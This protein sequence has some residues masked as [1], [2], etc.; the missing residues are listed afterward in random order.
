MSTLDKT[1]VHLLILGILMPRLPVFSLGL[2]GVLRLDHLVI[3]AAAP[4]VFVKI[5]SSLKYSGV[6][7]LLLLLFMVGSSTFQSPAFIIG[8][9]YSVIF[10]VQCVI[11]FEIA[12]KIIRFNELTILRNV[13][14]ALGF[15]LLIG[16]LSRIS[17][18]R[19]CSEYLNG[20]VSTTPCYVDQ[21]GLSGAPYV[22]GAHAVAFMFICLLLRHGS[23]YILGL[24]SLV[25]G[26]SRAFFGAF[27]PA[28][29]LQY[30]KTRLG[31]V[32][33]IVLM[34]TPVIFVYHSSVKVI[35]GFAPKALLDRSLGMRLENFENFIDWLTL[36]RVMLGNGYA[37]YLDFAVQYG[38][39]G[40]PDN[41]FIRAI[42]EF[43]LIGCLVVVLTLLRIYLN[44]GLRVGI[45][46]LT[47]VLGI[48]ALGFVQESHLANKS[49][50]ILA[51]VAGL[52]L[53]RARRNRSF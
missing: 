48:L 46:G 38:Q 19:L 35:Q 9:V 37:S 43:G 17:N 51:F 15:N 6:F 42:S 50:Q 28:S 53:I 18:F 1:F 27:M 25:L 22:F 2:L 11:Y 21:Y 8:A 23:A 13:F 44:S 24:L 49:G 16:F 41:L 30:L 34:F 4:L 47:V 10:I 20:S 45:I 5:L 52:A 26:D 14:Y 36:K 31:I 32:G 29:F 33:I 3:A 12:T 7:S 40:H 39:P